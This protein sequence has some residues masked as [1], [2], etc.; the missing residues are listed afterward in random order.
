LRRPPRTSR[1][2]D[3]HGRNGRNG[4]DGFRIVVQ[5]AK[6]S[7]DFYSFIM[8]YSYNSSLGRIIT[9]LYNK[10]IKINAMLGGLHHDSKAII[11]V[12]AVSIGPS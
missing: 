11:A 9:V 8:Y 6:H 3:R 1:R 4:Y 5:T 10:T 2:A 7:V 12:P